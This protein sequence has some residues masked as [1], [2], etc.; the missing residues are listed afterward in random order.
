MNIRKLT[1]LF[2]SAFVGL[3]V[4]A[5]DK[6]TGSILELSDVVTISGTKVNT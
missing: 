6:N 2:I 4:N 1:V 5:A 3:S